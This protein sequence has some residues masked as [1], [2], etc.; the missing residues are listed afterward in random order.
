MQWYLSFFFESQYL[1]NAF[2]KA[3]ILVPY[4]HAS[5]C[6]SETAYATSVTFDASIEMMK[7]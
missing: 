1:K 2:L 3:K 4:T 6:A 5:V 7:N